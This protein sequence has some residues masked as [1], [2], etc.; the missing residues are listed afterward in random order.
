[1]FRFFADAADQIGEGVD[2]IG[3]QSDLNQNSLTSI[4]NSASDIVF[5]VIGVIAVAILIYGG[6]QYMISEGNAAKVERA[7]ST[8]VWSI[9][10]LVIC[11]SSWAIV[12]FIV[13]NVGG[14]GSS[15]GSGASSSS[16]NCDTGNQNSGSGSN[17]DPCADVP[18]QYKD[19]CR[20][21]H[22]NSA[23]E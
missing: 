15:N 21:S 22:D 19:E 16:A 9:V 7:K 4:L 11:I 18:D 13:L 2:L 17:S 23:T 14:S 1:M 5:F 6:V 8:I 3:C 20:Q 10:G 12:N